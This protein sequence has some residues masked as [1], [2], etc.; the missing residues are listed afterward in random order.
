MSVTRAETTLETAPPKMKPTARPITP[1]FRI[2]STN[3][4]IFLL[5][6]VNYLSSILTLGQNLAK[7]RGS[8]PGGRINKKSSQVIKGRLFKLP[9][10]LFIPVFLNK[11][12]V[13]SFIPVLVLIV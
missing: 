12:S 13:G 11:P 3:P 6:M 9:L 8:P 7:G 4:R 5:L 1:C 2:K 10:M